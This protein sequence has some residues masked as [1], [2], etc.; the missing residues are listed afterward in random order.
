LTTGVPASGVAIYL[1]RSSLASRRPI[2][3]FGRYR[4]RAAAQQ[5]NGNGQSAEPL[6]Q[7]REPSCTIDFPGR[8]LGHAL[9]G[10][11][12]GLHLCRQVPPAGRYM[13]DFLAPAIGLV[14]E[15]DGWGHERRARRNRGGMKAAA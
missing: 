12:L 15:I 4:A 9:A 5:L 13:V 1:G 2:H 14:V 7:A 10:G 6:S 11:G 3:I 8:M